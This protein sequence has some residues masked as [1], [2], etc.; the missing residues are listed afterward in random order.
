MAVIDQAI[1]KPNT[2]FNYVGRAYCILINFIHS[3]RSIKLSG[4]F[5]MGVSTQETLQTTGGLFV[6]L[7]VTETI[8]EG[9]NYFKITLNL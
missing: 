8:S 9:L 7:M 2:L 1:S 6:F 5:L 4:C 3:I